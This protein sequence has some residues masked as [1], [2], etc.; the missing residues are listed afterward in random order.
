V[1]KDT[2]KRHCQK[3]LS[4]DTL[5]RHSRKTLSKDTLNRHSQRTL[6]KDAVKRHCLGRAGRRPISAP[7]TEA[8]ARRRAPK[9]GVAADGLICPDFF[10]KSGFPG[11]RILKTNLDVRPRFPRN[12]I[13]GRIPVK[14]ARFRRRLGRAGQRPISAPKTEALARRR[15][16]KT[17]VAADGLIC[18]NFFKKC[19]FPGIRIL[20]T[21]LDVRPRFPRY[22]ISGRIPVKG[23]RFRRR[24]G[25]AG[26]RPISGPKTEALAWRMAP[27][28]GSAADESFC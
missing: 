1:S 4:K 7:K 13:S 21:N 11:I 9:T 28:T 25:R 15:A 12:P 27:K 22:P 14:G 16:P 3:T 24:L 20:K 5:N 19:G 18:P 6:S 2:V 10:K 23:A 8:L 17:G 26:R